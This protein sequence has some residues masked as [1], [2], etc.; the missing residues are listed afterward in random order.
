[1]T[2]YNPRSQRGL[3]VVTS[4]VELH[5]EEREQLAALT[6]ELEQADGAPAQ[7]Q[8]ERLLEFLADPAHG[9]SAQA[10][11]TMIRK[12]CARTPSS[13]REI[14]AELPPSHL[15]HLLTAE[16]ASLFERQGFF[17][18][19]SVLPPDTVHAM[20]AVME[21]QEVEYAARL[22]IG[23]HERVNLL[24]CLALDERL[25]ELA[26]H[27]ATFPKVWGLMGWHIAL[28]IAQCTTYPPTA[29]DAL[30]GAHVWHRDSGTFS[31]GERDPDGEDAGYEHQVSIKVAYA[32][33]EMDERTGMQV[34]PGTHLGKGMRGER[35][36]IPS[37]L[38]TQGTGDASEWCVT[39][40]SLRHP[41]CRLSRPC[42]DEVGTE[43]SRIESIRC[44]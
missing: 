25:L 5:L 35:M 12:G 9:Q 34:I 30:D 39:F 7:Q 22:N 10:V 18:M 40:P 24:D 21:D 31:I 2:Q 15:D 27:P 41:L 1:M 4:D 36:H 11:M 32:L 44:L 8:V 26:D 43:C 28:Y 13:Q 17:V 3:P 14:L 16:E 42:G 23:E 38:G 20:Q 33:S 29:T 37:V 6:E 19:R